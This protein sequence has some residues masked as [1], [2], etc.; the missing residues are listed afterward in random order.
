MPARTTSI[1][2]QPSDVGELAGPTVSVGGRVGVPVTAPTLPSGV[3][4]GV[5]PSNCVGDG[6][7]VGVGVGPAN[8]HG[9]TVI[10]PAADSTLASLR[11]LKA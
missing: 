4:V 3:G 11:M 5:G 1:T 9:A 7:G 8:V 10:S 2:R 6:L